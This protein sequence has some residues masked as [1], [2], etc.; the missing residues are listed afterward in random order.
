VCESGRPRPRDALNYSRAFEGTPQICGTIGLR[1]GYNSSIGLISA[2][3]SLGRGRGFGELDSTELA[4]VSRAD[5][6]AR[7][8]EIVL[9][10]HLSP[11]RGAQPQLVV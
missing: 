10:S 9:N 8:A 4:E 3:G 6:P 5:A 11:S 1:S 7:Q 2:Q